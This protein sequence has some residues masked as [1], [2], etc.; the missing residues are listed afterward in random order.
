MLKALKA[1][2][3]GAALAPFLVGS[4]YAHDPHHTAENGFLVYSAIVEL[5]GG[6][7]WTSNVEQDADDTIEDR[8][9]PVVEGAARASIP[10]ASH[11]SFQF[12]L[13]GMLGINRRE[14]ASGDDDDNL[15][16]F[17]FASAHLTLRGS[18]IGA[19]GI[20]GSYGESSGGA[21][22]EAQV[23]F[24]GVEAQGYLGPVTLYAQGGYMSGDDGDEGDVIDKAY[25]G[26]GVARVFLG[27][28]AR[29]Q[30]E[31]AYITGEENSDSDEDEI[32]GW[33][34]GLRFDHAPGG[35]PVSYFLGYRGS[36]IE[37]DDTEAGQLADHTGLV[38]LALRLGAES[39]RDEDRRG[40]TLDTPAWAMGRW[41]G[42]TL[43][44][45]D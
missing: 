24:A 45:I 6:Y 2:A 12:D 10:L 3:V 30:A 15:Q 44:V 27:Q 28:N 31:G 23:W 1:L 37:S 32:Q 13:D 40:A 22:E 16:N 42:W 43:T 25:W 33:A 39:L 14:P 34:G 35:G 36:Y 29:L 38:G 11:L 20:L 21:D 26:R 8:D 41:T 7:L 4:A 17:F 5:G 9:F 18:S 19:L